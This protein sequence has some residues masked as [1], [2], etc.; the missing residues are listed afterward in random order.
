MSNEIGDSVARRRR[1]LG[2]SQ[3]ELAQKA[4][5][6]RTYV[7][8]IE[9]NEA[10][11]VSREVI[12]RIAQALSVPTSKLS[13]QAEPAELFIPPALKDFA[14]QEKLT[15]DVVEWLVKMPRRGPQPKTAGEW[16]EIYEVVKQL[17]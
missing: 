7:S 11:N 2:L 5:L 10:Q 13:G 14:V 6:S 12:E 15:L 8:L 9:R 4:K 3:D 17:L 1:E 16:R